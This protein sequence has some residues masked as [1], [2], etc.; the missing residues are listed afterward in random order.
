MQAWQTDCLLCAISNQLVV[1]ATLE[2]SFEKNFKA[3][4]RL[5]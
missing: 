2:Y 1:A 5:R 4:S 3:V